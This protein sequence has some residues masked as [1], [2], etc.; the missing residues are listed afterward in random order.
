MLLADVWA[1][2][3]TVRILGGGLDA[4]ALL[5]WLGRLPYPTEEALWG[6]GVLVRRLLATLTDT[7]IITAAANGDSAMV[8]G[9]LNWSAHQPDGRMI[10]AAINP[11]LRRLLL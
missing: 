2:T 4:E 6:E 9:A 1:Q 10:A 8:L 3:R 11:P 5:K 7:D